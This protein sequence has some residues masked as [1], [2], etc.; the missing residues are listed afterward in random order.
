MRIFQKHK[1]VKELEK[2]GVIKQGHGYAKKN[3][4]VKRT[5]YHHKE[6]GL[7]YKLWEKEYKKAHHFIKALTDFYPVSLLGGLVG[8]ILDDKLC[9]GYVMRWMPEIVSHKQLIE[10]MFLLMRRTCETRHYY[11]NLNPQHFRLHKDKVCLIDLEGVLP[12]SDDEDLPKAMQ[13]I[14][15]KNILK[16]FVDVDNFPTPYRKLVK[17]LKMLDKLMKLREGNF[18]KY[19]TFDELG[20]KNGE[21]S[22]EERFKKYCLGKILQADHDVLDIGCNVGFLSLYVGNFVKSVTG[23]D[24]NKTLIDVANAAQAALVR[25]HCTFRNKSA[26]NFKPDHKYDVILSLAVH[27][28][29]KIGF[30]DYGQRLW[31]MLKNDGLLVIETHNIF[32]TDLDIKDKIKKLVD[33]GFEDVTEEYRWKEE[34]DIDRVEKILA[35]I[36]DLKT[37]M[38]GK[39]A[40]ISKGRIYSSGT[41][42]G[43]KMAETRC[44]ETVLRP[45]EHYRQR[46]NHYSFELRF[47]VRNIKDEELRERTWAALCLIAC[48][49]LYVLRKPS[50]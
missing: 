27:R 38:L 21:R 45:A 5:V 39:G 6:S 29:L 35:E 16:K 36:D 34:V 46:T 25:P 26:E 43:R 50:Q 42:S 14:M 44:G 15:K 37:F 1:V 28:Y 31:E 13:D 3:P 30:K 11:Y 8:I 47:A 24:V 17:K 32:D 41:L 33:I 9:V 40:K 18:N 19:Q 4:K 48:R 7:V 20:I 12:I 22:T 10:T 23:I 2:A 49:D